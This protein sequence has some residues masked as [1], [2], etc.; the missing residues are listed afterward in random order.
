MNNDSLLESAITIRVMDTFGIFKKDMKSI[1]H[2]SLKIK[3][4]LWATT[5]DIEDG[6]SINA[7][8]TFANNNHY[9]L[10]SNSAN[11][12]NGGF[13]YCLIVCDYENENE[14]LNKVFI[15][16]KPKDDA[17]KVLNGKFRESLSTERA[18]LL[19]GF[20]IIRLYNR[21]LNKYNSNIDEIEIM[22]LFIETIGAK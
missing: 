11:H 8:Y 3:N 2:D 4:N 20:E 12:N 17:R 22:N 14:E 21:V 18:I 5:F 9:M 10:L 19:N 6:N 7:L 15:Y 16:N 1:I 13:Y